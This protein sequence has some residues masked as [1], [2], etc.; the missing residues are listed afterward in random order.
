MGTKGLGAKAR[1]VLKPVYQ[2]CKVGYFIK[3]Q[4]IILL[5]TI[6]RLISFA[7]DMHSFN[8]YR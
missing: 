6:G 7:E 5:F 1:I 3:F 4:L 8:T 2:A